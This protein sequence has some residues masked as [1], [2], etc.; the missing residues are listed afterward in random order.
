MSILR[1]PSAVI[2]QRAG[3][4]KAARPKGDEAVYVFDPGYSFIIAVGGA[5]KKGEILK[6]CLKQFMFRFR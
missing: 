3:S 2:Y 5:Q 1:P 6:S 4:G